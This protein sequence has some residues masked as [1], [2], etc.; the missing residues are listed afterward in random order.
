MYSSQPDITI[1]LPS[2]LTY[3]APGAFDK[4]KFTLKAKENTYAGFYTI[5]N[6][7]AYNYSDSVQ[8]LSWLNN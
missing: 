3:I 1:E 6:G 4:I 8:D 7:Y 2:S 5:E